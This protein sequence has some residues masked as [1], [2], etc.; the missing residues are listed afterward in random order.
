LYSRVHVSDGSATTWEDGEM[1]MTTR[2]GF[3]AA[4]ALALALACAGCGGKGI[5]GSTW[6]DT[7]PLPPDTLTVQT[8]EIGTYGGRFVLAQTAA[9]KTFNALMANET[10]STDVTQRLFAALT[11]YDNAT[12]QTLPGIA[13]SWEKSADGLT[14]TWHLRHGAAFSDG[15]PIT[16]ED[17]LFSFEVALDS[18]IHPS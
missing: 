15:H 10:S 8:G 9:P 2:G 13:R 12:Q 6:H 4:G 5:A 16:S 18:T 11:D 7:H 14:W 3:R 17:V 1:S